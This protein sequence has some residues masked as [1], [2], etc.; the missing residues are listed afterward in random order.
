MPALKSPRGFT[1][2]ELLV[3]LALMFILMTL[4]FP[5]VQS[6]LDAAK[7]AQAKN[8]VTQIATAMVAFDTE[9][10]RLP[11]TDPAP[12]Q[13]SGDVLKAL[14]AQNDTLNP[15]KIV[16]LEVQDFKRG[17]G[18]LK[19]GNFVDPWEKSY[20]FALD[21]DYDN[22][23]GVSTTGGVAGDSEIM[24]KVGVWNNNENRRRQVRSWD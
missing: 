19:G 12:Q 17:R 20:Y 22:H 6:A 7:K 11:S 8:D 2:I 10:G 5:A 18:G 4:L 9:Y 1:V 24:K 3:V 14:T 16:F 15:R 23:I 13:L 21:T